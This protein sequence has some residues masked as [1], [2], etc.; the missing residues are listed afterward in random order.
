MRRFA[1]EGRAVGVFVE[2]TPAEE[3]PSGKAQPGAAM[4]A[5]QEN[6]P[7]VPIARLRDA[8]L[9]AL[10]SRALLDRGRR[11]VPVRGRPK[12]GKRIQ[13]G[14]LEIE[15]RLNILFDWLAG[16]HARGRPPGETPPL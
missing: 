2:G 10:E 8:V 4:V 7:V 16:V 3:R 14:S 15:R 1:A 5:I 13:G 12:G 11:A 6:V 9:E